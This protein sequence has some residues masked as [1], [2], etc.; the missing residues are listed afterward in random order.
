MDK[1]KAF[2]TRWRLIKLTLFSLLLLGVSAC[3]PT[4]VRPPAPP[5][6][7]LELATAYNRNV[8]MIDQLWS[9]AAVEM[10]WLE[11]R[12]KQSESGEGHLMMVPPDCVALSVGKLGQTYFWLGC[13]SQ[14]YW[15]FDLR[16]DGVVYVGRQENFSLERFVNLPV[17]IK[18]LDVVKLLGLVYLPVHDPLLDQQ[19]VSIQGSDWVVD[20]PARQMQLTI[21]PATFTARRVRLFDDQG[22]VQVQATLWE[23]VGVEMYKVALPNLPKLPQQLTIDLPAQNARLIL[24]LSSL[25][26]GREEQRIKPRQFD[27][28][29]LLKAYKPGKTVDLDDR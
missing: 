10:E 12:K 25:T 22:A 15:F 19:L 29:A 5:V 16:D 3:T 2:Q 9:R 27:L 6:R 24:S 13:D 1:V 23:P 8:A 26:D 21:D 17:A 14:R 11:G 4:Q 18:P 28:Q 7:Y 20:L